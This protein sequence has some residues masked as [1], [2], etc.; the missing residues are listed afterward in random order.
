VIQVS[1]V[2]AGSTI[3]KNAGI[4]DFGQQVVVGKEV[5]KGAVQLV[6]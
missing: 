6:K 2:S 1:G 3:I 5:K 4:L